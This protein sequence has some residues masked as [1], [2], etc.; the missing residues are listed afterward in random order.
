MV[1]PSAELQG[2]VSGAQS[3][4]LPAGQHEYPFRFKVCLKLPTSIA[5]QLASLCSAFSPGPEIDTN[6]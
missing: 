1:F 2:S 4:T 3:Y 5:Q 6:I